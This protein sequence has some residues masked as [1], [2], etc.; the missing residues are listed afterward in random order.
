MCVLAIY[1]MARSLNPIIRYNFV[2]QLW[3]AV[4]AD[5]M[6][7]DTVIKAAYILS[8]QIASQLAITKLNNFQI[9]QANQL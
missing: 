6:K 5:A 9:W 3:L 7:Y 1:A 8:R 2:W 4:T